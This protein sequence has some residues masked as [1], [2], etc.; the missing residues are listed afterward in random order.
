MCPLLALPHIA[1]I[2]LPNGDTIVKTRQMTVKIG[3]RLKILLDGALGAYKGTMIG[4][5]CQSFLKMR[6]FIRRM[7]SCHHL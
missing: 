7:D 3:E 6:K 2:T 5:T 4:Y 1:S